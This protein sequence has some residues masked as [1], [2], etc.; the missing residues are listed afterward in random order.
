MGLLSDEWLIVSR[1]LSPKAPAIQ[2]EEMELAFHAGVSRTLKALAAKEDTST[3]P[4]ELQAYF[5]RRGLAKGIPLPV[6]HLG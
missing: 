3:W 1:N 4:A 5:E 6:G 2:R